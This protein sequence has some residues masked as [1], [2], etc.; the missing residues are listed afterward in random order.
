MHSNATLNAENYNVVPSL[1]LNVADRAQACYQAG[2]TC[3]GSYK[4]TPNTGKQL[5]FL[6]RI[7]YAQGQFYSKQRALILDNLFFKCYHTHMFA[8]DPV[9]NLT[10]TIPILTEMRSNLLRT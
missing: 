7:R 2:H 5:L 3:S 6:Y 4:G 8:R 1:T 9:S 10:Y